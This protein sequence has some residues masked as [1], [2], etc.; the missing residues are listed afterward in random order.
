MPVNH[1]QQ[2]HNDAQAEE[3]HGKLDEDEQG[4][5]PGGVPAEP[6]MTDRV[7]EEHDAEQGKLHQEFEQVSPGNDDS[8]LRFQAITAWLAVKV[9]VGAA[10]KKN[11]FPGGKSILIDR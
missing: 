4:S 6:G 8:W 7:D 9:G 11:T 3:E 5:A 10:S 1:G 2:P